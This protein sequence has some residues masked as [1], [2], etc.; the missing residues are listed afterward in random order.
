MPLKYIFIYSSHY[1]FLEL[2]IAA[3][4]ISVN[5]AVLIQV[6]GLSSKV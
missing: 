1:P 4:S 2:D 3:I 5:S 6:Q